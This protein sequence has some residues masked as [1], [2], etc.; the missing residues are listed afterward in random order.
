MSKRGLLIFLL[1]FAF[2]LSAWGNVIAAAFCPRYLSNCALSIKWTSL[3][4]RQ[5]E[6]KA[7]CH[8][9]MSEMEMGDMQMDESEMQGKA[10]VET[11]NNSIA[12]APSIQAETETSTQQIIID[13]PGETCGHCWMHSQPASGAATLVAVVPATGFIDSNAPPAECPVALAHD[14]TVFITPNEHGP[15][16]DTL[17]RH[18]RINI[19]RI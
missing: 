14:F 6:R 7:S 15:P 12:N 11:L 1:T 2:L 19:F 16:G 9:E 18:V 10:N 4:T 8:H 17:P 13:R 3:E 5:A